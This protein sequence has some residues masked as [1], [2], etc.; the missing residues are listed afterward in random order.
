MNFW[1]SLQMTASGSLGDISSNETQS[2]FQTNFSSLLH[3]CAVRINI[4]GVNG[5]GIKR[6]RITVKMET[7]KNQSPSLNNFLKNHFA[8]FTCCIYLVNS[9]NSLPTSLPKATPI[10]PIRTAQKTRFDTCFTIGHFCA[11]MPMIPLQ[12]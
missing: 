4:S 5:T 1:S 2:C 9:A 6:K 7:P 8:C 11:P 12:R 10:P 3:C